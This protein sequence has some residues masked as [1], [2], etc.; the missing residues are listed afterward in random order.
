MLLEFHVKIIEVS[1][2]LT[3]IHVYMVVELKLWTLIMLPQKI[4]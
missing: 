2:P 1:E 3:H 4:E